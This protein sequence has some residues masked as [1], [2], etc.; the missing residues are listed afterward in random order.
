MITDV[1]EI[2]DEL[3]I[4]VS[5][6]SFTSSRSGGPGGQHVN[7]VATRITLNFDV[8]NS[9]SLTDDQ[10]RRIL[11]K[12][13]TR[14]NKQ[15]ILRVVSQ[16]HRSQ[17]ANRDAALERFRE[18]I[19][20]ALRKTVPRIETKIPPAARQKRLDEKKRRSRLKQRRS[21]KIDIDDC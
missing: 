7:K 11:K 14:I 16:K 12:L 21:G 2:T 15:G 9:T 6:L 8:V 20:S 5:E 1:I 13:S 19:Q 3:S 17:K 10:R 4:P 18:L